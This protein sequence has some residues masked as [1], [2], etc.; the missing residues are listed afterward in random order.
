MGH[1]VSN[2]STKPD[3][4]KI[5]VVHF[6]EPRTIT[7]IKFFLGL[8]RYYWNYVRGDSRLVVLLFELTKKDVD[9]VWD[10]GYQ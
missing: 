10:L 9:F 3:F 4:N 2:E 7:N 6:S 8:T 5:D 1:V